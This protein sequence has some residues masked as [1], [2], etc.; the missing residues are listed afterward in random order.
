M[1][2]FTIRNCHFDIE[3]LERE[4]NIL[5]LSDLH[6]DI[7][8]KAKPGFPT[9]RRINTQLVQ[10]IKTAGSLWEPDVVIVAGDL[11]NL[12]KI[13]NY[14]YYYDLVRKLTAAYPNLRHTLFSTPGNHDVSRPKDYQ[15]LLDRIELLLNKNNRKS[16]IQNPLVHKFFLLT[17]SPVS[18]VPELQIA[19]S[20]FEKE[21]FKTYLKATHEM[22]LRKLIEPVAVNHP[23]P[24]IE[25]VYNTNVLGVNFVCHNSSFFCNLSKAKETALEKLIKEHLKDDSD[26]RNRLFLFQDLVNENIKTTRKFG[27]VV[28]FMHHPYHFLHESEFN[29]PV[30]TKKREKDTFNCF[31]RILENSNLI[32]CGHLH[33]NL[34][35]PTYQQQQAYI[36]MN[37]TSYYPYPHE[38]KCYP[39]TYALLK[40]NKQRNWFAMKKYV[41]NNKKYSYQDNSHGNTQHH[42]FQSCSKNNV[43][44]SLEAEKLRVLDYFLQLDTSKNPHKMYTYF[45]YQLGLYQDCFRFR[46]VEKKEF[47]I[48]TGIGNA[49]TKV[50]ILDARK[51]NGVLIIKIEEVDCWGTIKSK[52]DGINSFP[53][54]LTIYFSVGR[55]QLKLS[56]GEPDTLKINQLWADYRS[57]VLLSKMENVSINI[58]YH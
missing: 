24:S 27:P 7:D 55:S 49:K 40:V 20:E 47:W 22:K 1:R 18:K 46:S 15:Y 41:Y 30:V 50:V 25:T 2:K 39:F 35:D 26:D 37:G 52:L 42:E 32:L 38:G 10:S 57:Y 5:L 13:E 8:Q 54:G 9:A 4:V 31:S 44:T 11:V 48:H 45:I 53:P 51:K 58:L 43:S 3:R 14:K 23:L 34:Q 33:G 12:G 17:K 29:W 19:L 21:Y 6:Y 16:N 36:I 56:N 28:A